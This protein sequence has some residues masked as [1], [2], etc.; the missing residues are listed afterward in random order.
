MAPWDEPSSRTCYASKMALL[1]MEKE[2]DANK[3]V[4]EMMNRIK[5][6]FPAKELALENEEVLEGQTYEES[7]QED[8]DEFSHVEDPG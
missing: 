2:K 7:Y 8:P 4:E 3:V 6:L 5:E 1:Q